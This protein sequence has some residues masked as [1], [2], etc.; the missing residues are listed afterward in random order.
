MLITRKY[1]GKSADDIYRRVD[2]VMDHLAAKLSL[3]YQKDD[4]AKRGSVSKL[5]ITGTY[6]VRDGEVT[7][8]LKYPMLVPGPLRKQVQEDIERRLDRLFA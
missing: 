5:G 8:D 4:G 3:K 6:L 2:A 1:P 7:V